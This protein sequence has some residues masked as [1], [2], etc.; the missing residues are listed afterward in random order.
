M[1]QIKVNSPS[2]VV[3][4]AAAA[5]LVA[6]LQ[7]GDLL[8]L[9]PVAYDRTVRQLN[10]TRSFIKNLELK[11]DEAAKTGE[12]DAVEVINL[13]ADDD[14]GTTNNV[15]EE[16]KVATEARFKRKIAKESKDDLD[17]PPAG[18]RVHKSGELQSC[19]QP[20]FGHPSAKSYMLSGPCTLTQTLTAI[21]LA[22][23]PP[24][25]P[26]APNAS[27]AQFS[28]QS[29][30]PFA[31]KLPSLPCSQKSAVAPASNQTGTPNGS[32]SATQLASASQN[33]GPPDHNNEQL[34]PELDG[35]GLVITLKTTQ[36]EA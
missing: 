20:T 31:F 7:A 1:S 4:E 28:T 11:L 32:P 26:P 17:S 35:N 21:K 2:D 19:H 5:Q 6:N 36:R 10:A 13:T 27:V 3:F 8:A 18:K 30:T 15:L 34:D 9:C 16:V 14:A 12:Q 23:I 25:F 24:R 22:G 33:N 29:S